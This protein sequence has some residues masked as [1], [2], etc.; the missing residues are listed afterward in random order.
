MRRVLL[1]AIVL[2][3]VSSLAHAQ[4]VV[5][6]PDW[7]RKPTAQNMFLVWPREALREGV[8]G[9]AL[10]QCTVTVQGS[11][12]DCLVLSESP[13]AMGFGQA[14]LALTPQFLMRPGTIDGKPVE[15]SIRV[16][17]A[18]KGTPGFVYPTMNS[19][20]IGTRL[21]SAGSQN[22]G[23]VVANLSWI[24]APSY[25]QVVAAYPPKARDARA[26][27]HVVLKCRLSVD[28]RAE[29]CGAVVEE[30]RGLGFASAAMALAK[31]FRAPLTDAD[32]SS[33]RGVTTQIAFT[34]AP[35]MLGDGQPVIGKPQWTHLPEALDLAASFPAQ[36][37]AA[38]V[39]VG[40]VTLACDVGPGGHL[41]G[42]AVT[43]QA[44]DGLGFDK[45]AL[46]LAPSFQ[47]TV[48]TDEGLPTV[49]G[50]ITVPI[51]YEAGTPPA[52][53]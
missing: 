47:V 26:G 22:E 34:F 52:A 30:P 48:W 23:L 37:T 49:G 27:G 2:A 32:G 40:H 18:F 10:I 51:R 20:P 50:R 38:H 24:A 46:A 11:L 29:P 13:A 31:D 45:A 44:P 21:P 43:R 19:P 5:T 6:N 35:E 25:A 16:P 53:P 8:S 33:I 42:C 7:I 17:I 28:G 39:S 41:A 4:H 1:S 36:A 14:A 3:T 12:R 15:S 9:R